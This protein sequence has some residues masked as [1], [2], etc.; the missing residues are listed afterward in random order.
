[1][2]KHDREEL[3][4]FRLTCSISLRSVAQ[5]DNRDQEEQAAGEDLENS[6]V[7]SI[8]KRKTN[9]KLCNL[10]GISCE[11]GTRSYL[12]ALVT[13]DRLIVSIE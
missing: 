4:Y 5:L 2:V 13:R 7:Q 3:K 8:H 1:M 9:K 6:E 12:C 10:P 11:K